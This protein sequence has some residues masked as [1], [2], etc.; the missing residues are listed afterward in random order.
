[1]VKAWVFGTVV[2]LTS[3]GAFAQQPARPDSETIRQRQR[4]ALIEGMLERAVQNGVDNFARKIQALVPNADGMAMLMGAPQVRGFRFEQPGPSGVFFDVL[5]PSLQLSMVWPLRAQAADPAALATLNDLRAQLDRVPDPQTRLD[6]AQRV[7]QLE[8]Q[9]G[10]QNSRR[11]LGPATTV[12]NV[13]AATTDVAPVQGAAPTDTAILDDPAEAWR[14]E[15]RSTLIDAMIEHVSLP[16]GPDEYVVIAARGV[17]S[18]DRLVSD[19]GDART[20]ELRLK[21]SDLAAFR[22]QAISLEEARTR[23]AVREY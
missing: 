4:I 13:Q 19:P 16:I 1:V 2:L 12:A 6:L 21:G 17:L 18:S 5:M 8:L 3:A 7:R 20:I 11:R 23:V 9:L 10:P 14:N 22:A 15:V